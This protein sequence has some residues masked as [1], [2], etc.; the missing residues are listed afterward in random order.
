MVLLLVCVV[1]LFSFARGVEQCFVSVRRFVVFRWTML[2]A[3][4]RLWVED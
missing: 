3:V 1:V 2:V 4:C